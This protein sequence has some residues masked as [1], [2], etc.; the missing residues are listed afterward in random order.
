MHIVIIAANILMALA[1]LYSTYYICIHRNKMEQIIIAGYTS[2]EEVKF[3]RPSP[4]P[5]TKKKKG[6]DSSVFII[7]IEVSAKLHKIQ[8]KKPD[9]ERAPEVPVPMT[10]YDRNSP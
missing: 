9:V 7:N 3:T 10:T 6:D 8:I 1:L 5:K 2:W 4:P